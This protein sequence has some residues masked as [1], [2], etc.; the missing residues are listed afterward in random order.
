MS[1]SLF[2][3]IIVPIP[4]DRKLTYSVPS[5]LSDEISAGKRVVVPVGKNKL[6]SGLVTRVH[7]ERP[8]FGSV[9]PVQAVLD[10]HPIVGEAHLAFWDWVVSYYLCQPGDVFNCAVPSALRLQSETTLV[11]GDG[12]G[13]LDLQELDEDERFLL[14]QVIEKGSVTI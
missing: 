3:E 11:P 8:A 13:D 12:L 2:A 6:Y 1:D 5:E 9:K 14:E 10:D 7:N 4:I